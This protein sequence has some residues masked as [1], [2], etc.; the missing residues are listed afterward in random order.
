MNDEK[1]YE[2]AFS[3]TIFAS[4]ISFILFICYNIYKDFTS[5]SENELFLEEETP[6]EFKGK[7]I[8]E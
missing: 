4:A 3:I 8:E 6:L 5:K 7:V 2:K 1:K